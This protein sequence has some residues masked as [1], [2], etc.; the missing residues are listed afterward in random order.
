M[1][2]IVAPLLAMTDFFE[3][4]AEYCVIESGAW[5]FRDFCLKQPNI[6]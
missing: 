2:C 3:L 1:D 5:Q 6:R 4:F